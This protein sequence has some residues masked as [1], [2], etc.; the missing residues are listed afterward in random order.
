VAESTTS[1]GIRAVMMETARVQLAAL[2]A[3]IEFW[4]GWVESA[5]KFAQAAN[6]ELAK[7][8]NGDAKV[9]ETLSRIADS[10]RVYLE[11]MTELPNKAVSRFNADLQTFTAK[12][13]EATR[14]ARAKE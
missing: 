7:I 14:S 10:S 11:T 1:D 9:D 4:S 13:P 3:G 12:K 5:S 6:L 8:S 2:N